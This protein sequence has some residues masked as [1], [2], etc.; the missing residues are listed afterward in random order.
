MA[1]PKANVGSDAGPT[2][3]SSVSFGYIMVYLPVTV[4]DDGEQES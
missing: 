2:D 4:D 3:G 1:Q